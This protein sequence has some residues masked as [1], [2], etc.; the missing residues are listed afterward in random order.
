M[1]NYRWRFRSRSRY[2]TRQHQIRLKEI[3]AMKLRCSEHGLLSLRC[4]HEELALPVIGKAIMAIGF[5]EIVIGLG[6][7][8]RG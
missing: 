3:R 8:S 1:A 7:L 6:F 2:G 4:R 5:L